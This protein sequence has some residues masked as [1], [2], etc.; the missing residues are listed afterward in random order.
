MPISLSYMDLQRP[1]YYLDSLFS[2]AIHI[3]YS[4]LDAPF[5]WAFAHNLFDVMRTRDR[6]TFEF[7][8]QT[9]TV[10]GCSARGPSGGRPHPRS[11]HRRPEL[12]HTPQCCLELPPRDAISTADEMLDS[13]VTPRPLR[14]LP[15]W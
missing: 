2:L 3:C 14:L 8:G 15:S 12:V 1:K 4:K 9:L 7:S 6:N 11:S 13:M 10:R 5:P